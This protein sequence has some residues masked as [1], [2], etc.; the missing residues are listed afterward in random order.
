MQYHFYIFSLDSVLLFLQISKLFNYVKNRKMYYS[1]L[2]TIMP[3]QK[4]LRVYRYPNFM[5][6]IKK[7]IESTFVI[8]VVKTLCRTGEIP[9][10]R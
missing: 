1:E 8:L 7:R 6:T 10:S 5:M 2:K 4:F 3:L 9:R